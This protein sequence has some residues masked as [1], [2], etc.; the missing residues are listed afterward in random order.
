ML[1]MRHGTILVTVGAVGVILATGSIAGGV[2]YG[3]W[4]WIRGAGLGW[5]A[6]NLIILG[7]AHAREGHGLFGKRREGTLPLWSKVAFLPLF[8]VQSAVWHLVR[9]GPRNPKYQVVAPGLIVGRRPWLWEDPPACTT[10]VDLT[11]EYQ[12]SVRARRH[13]G[14][15][16]LPLLDG[17]APSPR[18]LVEFI[19]ALPLGET[20]VHCAQGH[21]RAGLFA[22]VWM[23]RRGNARSVEEA[24]KAIKAVRPRV[25]LNATQRRCAEECFLC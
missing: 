13:P 6:L 18:V 2:G 25:T 10:L 15:R 11:S 5:F 24:L 4:H 9:L 3:R 17:S 20:F 12:E 19:D 16:C 14:Y 22:V 1:G 23:L 21:G 7:L 8:V